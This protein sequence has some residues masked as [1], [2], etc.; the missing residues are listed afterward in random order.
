MAADLRQALLPSAANDPPA[1]AGRDAT[2]PEG[3]PLL[4]DGVLPPTLPRPPR[5]RDAYSLKYIYMGAWE[6]LLVLQFVLTRT[7][8]ETLKMPSDADA[9]DTHLM[10][11]TVSHFLLFG[12]L[13][14]WFIDI[15]EYNRFSWLFTWDRWYFFLIFFVTSPIYSYVSDYGCMAHSMED[16]TSWGPGMWAA[17]GSLGGVAVIFLLVH[18]Y[19][20]ARRKTAVGFVVYLLSRLV[21][22]GFYVVAAVFLGHNHY[23]NVHIHHYFTAWCIALFA[24]FNHP[25]S[26]L[27]LAM[28]ASIFVQGSSSYSCSPLFTNDDCLVSV[29]PTTEATCIFQGGQNFTL[30]I[31]PGEGSAPFEE[32]TCYVGDQLQPDVNFLAPMGL[33]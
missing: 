14:G 5:L 30:R 22:F 15:T 3:I 21:V 2:D 27:M 10:Y 11:E 1:Q 23:C 24:E 17:V 8:A 32:A 31:C 28:S 16:I 20:A 12:F 19:L 25:I 13:L 33:Q 4:A 9:F 18:L 29:R 26:A 6:G 7:L